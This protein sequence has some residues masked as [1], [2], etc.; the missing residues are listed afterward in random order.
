MVGM[1]FSYVD[2]WQMSAVLA[3]VKTAVVRE[4]YPSSA[5]RDTDINKTSGLI[6]DHQLR[7]FVEEED[8]LIAKDVHCREPHYVRRH[9]S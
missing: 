1:V 2:I 6:P 7:I 9:I 4:N 8:W 5:N 3:A